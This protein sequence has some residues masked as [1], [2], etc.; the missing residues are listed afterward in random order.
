MDGVIDVFV[1]ADIALQ[2]T[3]EA[4]LD[5]KR[6]AELLATEEVKVTKVQPSTKYVL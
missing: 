4:K 1:N 2:L 6:L 3:K 5:E